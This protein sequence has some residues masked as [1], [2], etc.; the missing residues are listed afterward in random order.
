MDALHGVA[1]AD[2]NFLKFRPSARLR[3][4]TARAGRGGGLG[5]SGFW[6]TSAPAFALTFLGGPINAWSYKPR[7]HLHF[8]PRPEPA[9]VEAYVRQPEAV[10]RHA[11]W[12]M[13]RFEAVTTRYRPVREG[14]E[15]SRRERVREKKQ[16]TLLKSAHLDGAILS[17]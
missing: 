14:D 10:A 2:G 6:Q 12:P 9:T 4:V 13:I 11:F 15:P 1:P 16:R 5:P 17:Y 8:D 3:E 7:R